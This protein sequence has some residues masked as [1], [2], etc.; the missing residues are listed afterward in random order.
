MKVVPGAYSLTVPV[1]VVVLVVVVVDCWTA[2]AAKAA[3][4][5][6]ARMGSRIFFIFLFLFGV[7]GIRPARNETDFVGLSQ[8]RGRSNNWMPDICD[9]PA[10][11][12][13]DQPCLHLMG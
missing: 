10:A 7:T 3:E 1:L 5:Q 11:I 4:A 2:S 13:F 9:P 12:R 8:I 6:S